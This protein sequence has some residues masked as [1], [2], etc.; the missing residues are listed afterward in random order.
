MHGVFSRRED[1]P[2]EERFDTMVHHRD[3]KTGQISKKTPYTLRVVNGQQRFIRDGV[4]FY[5]NGKQV[6]P[7]QC[8]DEAMKKNN[9]VEST[10]NHAFRAEDEKYIHPI[11]GEMFKVRDE[12]NAQVKTLMGEMVNI[13]AALRDQ[14]KG[15]MAGPEAPSL[16][17]PPKLEVV[18]AKVEPV[19]A[20]AP[21]DKK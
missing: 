20:Q 4:E 13:A 19:Q 6:N 15:I 17:A 12:I 3:P 16:A 10:Q 18:P 1:Y 14:S 8:I 9:F 11:M 21:K 5:P 2:A 7:A